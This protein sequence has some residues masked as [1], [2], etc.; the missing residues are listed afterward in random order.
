ML[1]EY[2]EKIS[3]VKHYMNQKNLGKN[4]QTRVKNYIQYIIDSRA[5]YRPDEEQFMDLLSQTLKDEIVS[6]VNGKILAGS[7]MFSVNFS[8]KAA[9]NLAKFMKETFFAPEEVVFE[10]INNIRNIFIILYNRKEI[11]QI[12]QYISLP[13]GKFSC[14]IELRN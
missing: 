8:R 12:A 3:N 7:R 14:I 13:M 6:E 4:I 1:I 11:G 2:R 10:V 5:L 9:L